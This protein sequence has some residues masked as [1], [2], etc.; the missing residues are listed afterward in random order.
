MSCIKKFRR[1]FSGLRAVPRGELV[2][3]LFW[4]FTCRMS[5]VSVAR[6]PVQEVASDNLARSA[7]LYILPSVI[8]LLWAK[9]SQYLLGRF[10][11]SFHQ[12]EGICVNFVDQV[13]FFRFLEGRCHGNQFCVVSKTQTACDY[14]NFYT[15]GCRWQ[16]WNSFFQYLEGF[17]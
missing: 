10:S 16:I 11:R 9:L 2:K 17:T 12:M 6:L 15:F 13:Q 7:N 8:F 4:H 3:Q 14:C 1:L 5:I